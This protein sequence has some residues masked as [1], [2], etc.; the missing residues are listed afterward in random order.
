MKN[1]IQIGDKQVTLDP[2]TDKEFNELINTCSHIVAVMIVL[3]TADK[4]D[5]KSRVKAVVEMSGEIAGGI[6]KKA[7]TI[8]GNEKNTIV[9]Q[10]APSKN[11]LKEEVEE[12]D[13]EVNEEDYA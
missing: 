3:G 10:S 7:L 1:Y 4:K 6:A 8:I 5:D 11:D 2:K 9:S 13:R 12:D